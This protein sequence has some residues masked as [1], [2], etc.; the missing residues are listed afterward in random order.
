M[1]SIQHREDSFH[2]PEMLLYLQRLHRPLDKSMDVSLFI[3]M[4][5]AIA[6]II[7]CYSRDQCLLEAGREEGSESHCFCSLFAA[8]QERSPAASMSNGNHSRVAV[9]YSTSTWTGSR[10][11]QVSPRRPPR[12]VPRALCSAQ[13][14]RRCYKSARLGVALLYHPSSALVPDGEDGA[15]GVGSQRV[16][17]VHI[18]GERQDDM[19]GGWA[20]VHLWFHPGVRG[21]HHS[22]EPLQ[23]PH[24]K[25]SDC[26]L[27]FFFF[28]F[29]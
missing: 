20:E 27:L 15:K 29:F 6:E 26:F 14:E 10:G 1:L 23:R 19:Q 18:P 7:N 9:W 11:R 2:L 12:T 16:E 13:M 21:C 25:Y 3:P 4:T 24:H 17:M 28:L 8:L 5:A 22:V